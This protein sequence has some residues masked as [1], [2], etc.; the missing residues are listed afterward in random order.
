MR[1]MRRI[2]ADQKKRSAK[3]RRIRV[4]RVPIRAMRDLR[5]TAFDSH[6]SLNKSELLTPTPHAGPR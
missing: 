3:I 5:L 2:F 6:R 4:I 1:Q